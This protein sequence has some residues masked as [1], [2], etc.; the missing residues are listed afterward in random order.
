MQTF[1]EVHDELKRHVRPDGMSGGYTLDAMRQFMDYIDNPQNKVR[2]IHVA[3]SSGKTS[4]AYYIAGTLTKLGYK[5]SLHVSPHVDEV[6]E[7]A[8]INMQ[9]LAEVEF[10]RHFSAYIELVKS[11]TIQLSYFEI[12]VGFAYWLFAEQKVDYAVIEVGLG[13]LLD[14]TNVI[15]REDKISVITD[16]T[17]DHTEVLGDTLPKI[18]AQKAGIILPNSQAFMLEQPTEIMSVITAQPA[19][20]TIVPNHDT[21]FR[22][23]NAALASAVINYLLPE[24]NI[25]ADTIQVPGRVEEIN[26]GDQVVIMDGSHNPQKVAA[27]ADA[28]DDVD[29]PLLIAFGN[30][31]RSTIKESLAQ[32]RRVGSK[33]IITEFPVGQDEVRA[34]I[35]CQE[36]TLLCKEQQFEHII[37]EKDPLKAFQM[38]RKNGHPKALITG[39]YFLLNYLRNNIPEKNLIK[40]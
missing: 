20:I 37:C 29:L 36:L 13:G 14:A 18:A 11:S 3:G 15:T 9:P 31:K 23:R 26:F 25:T 22:K 7:R 8:Q 35:P 16:I 17:Y 32:L 4:T 38:L 28:L 21:D 40:S 34:A 1:T 27:L 30:N 2:V 12:L 6:N 24:N 33:V 5:T 19:R 39:S 10:C